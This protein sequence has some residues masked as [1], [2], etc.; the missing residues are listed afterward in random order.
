MN[1]VKKWPLVL[2]AAL[3]VTLI[4]ASGALHRVDKW[5]QDWLFQRPGAPSGDIVVIGIDEAAFDAL[6]PYQTWDRSV[7]AAA[8]EALAADPDSL[9]AAV[10]VDVLY[11]GDTAPEA[12]QRLARAAEALGCVVTASMAEFGTRIT[13]ESGRP[14]SMETGIAT[15]YEEPYEAL[16]Q[17][18]V[19]GHINAMVDRDGVLRHALLSV[20]P[21]GESGAPVYSMAFQTARL[22]LAARGQAL[23]EPPAGPQGHFY[24]P[25]TARPGGYYDGVSIAWLMAG[26]VPSGYWKDKIVL[27]GP[28]AAALQDAYFTSID[29]GAQMY[30]VEVQANVIQSLIEGRYKAEIQD[31]PQLIALFLLSCAAMTL[32]LRLRVAPGAGVCAGLMLLSVGGATLLY[33]AGW[34]VHPLWLAAAAPALY[35]LALAIHYISVAR[36]RRALALEKERIGAELALATRIQANALPKTFPPFPDRPEFDIY[37]SMTPAKEV[38]GDLYDFF[39]IDDDHLAL[40]IGDVSGKGVPASLFM[41]VAMALIHH[42]AMRELSPAKILQIVNQEICS[43]NPEEMFVTVWLGVLEISTGRLT[44]ANAGHEYPAL[45]N[46]GESFEL[47]KDKHGFVIGGMEGVRY[48]E[49]DIALTPG[50]K[51]FVYTDGV[52]EATDAAQ[53]LFGT[54]RMLD[55]LRAGEEGAP[56]DVLASV[57]RAVQAFVGSAPQ[58]DDLTMLCLQYNGPAGTPAE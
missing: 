27:I 38:G 20:R 50:S 52:A 33:E 28:C 37:A 40:T 56:A 24:I 44:A 4:I 46:P 51:L 57:D 3:L 7:M 12:D 25:Y 55:A 41:M 1:G 13:W 39:L 8:L 36:E 43:R 34:V 2:V 58:F 29:K 6:G 48:R 31:P 10:A 14:V 32:F 45:K 49:Y 22:Y 47:L 17:A 19:Q 26:K 15:A 23:K 21:E 35:V 18:T 11:A 5:A 9:P 42:V 16:R 54:D 30:G 53:E